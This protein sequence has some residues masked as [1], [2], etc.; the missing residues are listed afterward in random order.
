MTSLWLLLTVLSTAYGGPVKLVYRNFDK[1]PGEDDRF[2]SMVVF[3][4]EEEMELTFLE[5]VGDGET[6]IPFTEGI[7]WFQC[8]ILKEWHAITSDKACYGKRE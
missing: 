4:L 2:Q 7:L 1:L 6:P 8:F 3:E 5:Y